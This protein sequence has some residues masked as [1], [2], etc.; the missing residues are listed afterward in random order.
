MN[1]KL[2]ATSV[3]R[4]TKILLLLLL[5][6][7]LGVI[8]LLPHGGYRRKVEAY[9][10][11]LLAQGEKLTMLELAP[12]PPTNGPNGAI[13]LTN[14]MEG[15]RVPSDYPPMMKIVGPGIAMVGHSNPRP[16]E[17]AGYASN[18]VKA[19]ELRA[20]LQ[21][22]VL[23][24]NLD[25]SKGS[26]L[27]LYHLSK[28]KAAESLLS[29]TATQALH[30]KDYS[31]AWSNLLAGV[32]LVR[33]YDNEP[34][35]I[36][37]LVRIAM[38]RIAI[39]ATWE[40]LHAGHQ[41]S[42]AQLAELQAKWQQVNLFDHP[43]EVTATERAWGINE[44]AKLRSTNDGKDLFLVA[45]LMSG[46]GGF[47]TPQ[48]GWLPQLGD[49]AKELYNRYPRFW[50][51]K[52]SGSYDE[53]LYDLQIA[54]TA[55][56]AARRIMKADAFIPIYNELLAE[57]TNALQL[58][59]QAERHFLLIP[60]GYDGV[61]TKYLLKPADAETARRLTVTAIA[62]ERYHLQHNTYPVSLNELVPAFLPQVP[63]DFMDGKPLRYRLQ[64]DGNFLLYSVGEDGKDDGGDATPDGSATDWTRARD[65]VWPRAA[66]PQ[67]LEDYLKHHPP[68]T[69]SPAK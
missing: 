1:Y 22:P 42:A 47:Q 13:A 11:Q 48:G 4:R 61:F 28:L 29:I 25:Y 8:L 2:P 6:L 57:E 43:D 60:P 5:A 59:P 39:N 32:E 24:F 17:M 38:A 15:Y 36:S 16:V 9:K 45:S 52:S 65:I 20:I 27:P 58:H 41:W 14:A 69:N 49:K 19:A 56:M 53:E 12:P 10:K 63:T 3:K 23:D 54:T 37:D 21:A 50:L 66:T 18:V 46:S 67:E 62:L 55:E 44:F 7:I 35:L 51:W 68:E 26:E 64:P 33:L 31:E 40:A 34:I 30:E